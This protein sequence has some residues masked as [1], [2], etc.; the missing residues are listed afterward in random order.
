M[1][2]ST[3]EILLTALVLVAIG[4]G[5]YYWYWLKPTEPLDEGSPVQSEDVCI[6]KYRQ[7]TEDEFFEGL[8][9]KNLIFPHNEAGMSQEELDARMHKVDKVRMG[10]LVCRI[11]Y[12]QDESFYDDAIKFITEDTHT[13]EP[14]QKSIMDLIDYYKQKPDLRR[15]FLVELALGDLGEICPE[16]L[17]N[18]CAKEF[19]DKGVDEFSCPD[20]CNFIDRYQSDQDLFER[21]IEN[22]S[23]WNQHSLSGNLSENV[24]SGRVKIRLSMFI[25]IKGIDAADQFCQDLP[26]DELADSDDSAKE[27]CFKKLDEI[28]YPCKEIKEKI[29]NPICGIDKTN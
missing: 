6:E 2:F 19:Q 4:S 25:R 11:K 14:T 10:Y 24:T 7:M 12:T 22:Y 5:V 21:E 26:E 9:D 3:K 17:F 8:K 1:R 15:G 27:A 20:Y 18:L 16:K 29:L 23:Y 28:K 13:S